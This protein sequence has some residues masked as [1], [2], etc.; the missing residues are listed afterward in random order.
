[1]TLKDDGGFVGSGVFC[2]VS[3]PPMCMVSNI[4]S[5][6]VWSMEMTK[7]LYLEAIGH[8]FG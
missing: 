6:T 3:S 2:V 8:V 5:I 1:M 7:P 4:R